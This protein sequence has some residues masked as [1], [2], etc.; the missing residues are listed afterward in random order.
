M[1]RQ[2]PRALFARGE[3]LRRG[4]HL[5]A[6]PV[7]PLPPRLHAPGGRG[8]AGPAPFRG[9]GLC[10]R[11]GGQRPS[12]RGTPGRLLAL[13]AGH[14]RPSPPT[15]AQHPLGGSPRPYR[16]GH[17][18]QRQADP[19]ARRDVLPGPERHLADRLARAGAGKLY[20]KPHRHPGLRRPDRDGQSPYRKAR[21]RG[22]PLGRRPGRRRDHRRGLGQR[23]GRPR[24]RSDPEHLGGALLSVESRQPLPLRPDRGHDAGRGRGVRHRTQLLRPPQ[25]G[26][27]RGRAG[28]QALFPERKAHPP[29]RPAG[30]GLLARGALHPALRRGGGARAAHRAGAG[31][32]S[33]AQARQ[34][35]A[36]AVVLPLR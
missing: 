6:R 27:Q 7:A 14:H 20:R 19:Q 21:R 5:A 22:E 24:R 3:G 33:A 25:V 8:R 16:R 4:P 11:G 13:H 30:S 26:V 18:G 28:H 34:D 12:G 31:L 15:G 10:L 32:Q 17:A 9:G 36:G 29:Q 23:R 2:H 35:R 1:G